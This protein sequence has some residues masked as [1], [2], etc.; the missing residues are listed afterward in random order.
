M[1]SG[2]RQLVSAEQAFG[3]FLHDYL[4]DPSHRSANRWHGR[5]A[6]LLGLP[7]RIGKRVFIAILS[8][9]VPGTDFRLGRVLGGEHRHRPGWDLTFSAPKSVS[10]EALLHGERRVMRA[11][12]RAVRETLDWIEAEFLQTRGY[13]PATGRR[14]REAAD[15][16]IAATF[17]H[18]AS[19]NNDP[20]LHTHV[21]LANMTLSQGGAWRSVEPTLLIRNRRLIGAWYR[22]TLA[23]I[24]GEAGYNLAPTTIGGL[25]GF[26]LAGYS[27]AHL[28]AFSSRR[29]DILRYMAEEGLDYSPGAAQ[30]AALATRARKDEPG[31][32]MLARMWQ[33]VAKALGLARDPAAVRRGKAA[34]KL[35]RAPP[36]FS[37]LEAAWQALEHLEERYPVFRPQELLAT[38]L[39]RD[40]G[41]H[42]HTELEAAITRLEGDGHLVRTKAGDYTTRRT[43]RAET[44]VISLMREGRG[45]TGMMVGKARVEAHLAAAPLTDGQREAASHILLS[46]D[47]VIGVQGFAGTGKTRMLNE[48]TRLAGGKRVFGLAPSSAAARVLGMEAGIGATTLQYLLARYG[49]I[50][51][52]TASEAE[53]EA[54][55]EHF[56]GSIM[57]LDESSMV[58]TVQMQSLLR[59]ARALGLGRLVLVGD[60]MQLK[61]VS[62]GQPFRLLQKAGMATA[63][64]DDILRQRSADL[65]GAVAHMVAGDPE[66]AMASLGG[67]VRELPPD[68][69]GETAARLWLGLPE[70]ARTETAILAP[71]HAL[72]EEINAVIREGLA[73]EGVLRG[74]SLE[75]M[76]LVDRRLT[77]P[78]A[79]DAASYRE[80]DVVIANRAVYGLREGEAWHVTGAG[81]ER[82]GLAREG[83]EGGFRP[84]GNCRV[85][86]YS[87]MNRAVFPTFPARS[88]SV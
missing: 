39:G 49:A 62:A 57:I 40:P 52:G 75:I 61:A 32:G 26:E 70:A 8:G 65:K 11:H 38:A 55:R 7:G 42:A 64:M 74:T 85:S 80:G 69:L 81:P 18:V 27:Q 68:A 5:G 10:L 23:R 19:R 34:G 78:L 41:R 31:I 33:R 56:A 35:K 86:Y 12:D 24:L 45:K 60:T 16:M 6:R 29:Q 88:V 87:V 21:V 66:L 71:T 51:E 28:D 30:R 79:A 9:H 73:D 15:G 53:L 44:E 20:Q 50:A 22:N 77:R 47:R 4:H 14:P 36:R 48:I 72:R 84:A 59:I 83:Q 58:G 63:R 25:P 76:R 82:V 3:Y 1:L 2:P 13:D 46:G 54:A 43:L 37:A 17:R 67:D